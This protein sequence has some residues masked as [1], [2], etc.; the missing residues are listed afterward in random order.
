M[1]KAK[2]ISD[3]TEK[4]IRTI[5]FKTDVKFK[6]IWNIEE[7]TGDW[8]KIDKFSLSD[9]HSAKVTLNKLLFN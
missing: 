7:D 8:I 1:K 3:I 5:I 2:I 4:D 6:L 9:I